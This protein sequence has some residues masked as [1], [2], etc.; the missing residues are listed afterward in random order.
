MLDEQEYLW[1]RGLSR[2]AALGLGAAALPAVR[3]FRTATA[4][5]AT[6]PIVKPLPADLFTVFGSNAEMKWSAMQSQWHTTHVVFV[7]I[8]V[9]HAPSSR[10]LTSRTCGISIAARGNTTERNVV[11]GVA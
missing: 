1:E 8:T 9:S 2:R 4:R 6:T 5:A 3:L 10:R 7:R 11:S